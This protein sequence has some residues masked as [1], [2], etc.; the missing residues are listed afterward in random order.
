MIYVPIYLKCQPYTCKV[1]IAYLVYWVFS[2]EN[3]SDPYERFCKV[4]FL[5]NRTVVLD[6]ELFLDLVMS[7][8]PNVAENCMLQN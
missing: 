6:M 1:K 3:E 5:L 7:I 2:Q 4:E 8:S